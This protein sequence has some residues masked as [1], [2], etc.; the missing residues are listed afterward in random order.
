MGIIG[1]R[2]GRGGCSRGPREDYE[3]LPHIHH[4][5]LIGGYYRY[6]HLRNDDKGDE[7]DNNKDTTDN[8][9]VNPSLHN[10]T[11]YNR[12]GGWDTY[13]LQI[14][15]TLSASRGREGCGG[16]GGGGGGEGD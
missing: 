11:L 7:K 8:T 13:R 6:L 16:R 2:E 14:N 12:V 9:A 5:A 3:D 4:E 10:M 1:S 15:P